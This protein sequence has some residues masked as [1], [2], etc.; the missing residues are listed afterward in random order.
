MT[1][2]ILGQSSDF[3][4]SARLPGIDGAFLGRKADF[5]RAP[6]GAKQAAQK[7]LIP[8]EIGGKYPSVAKA[9]VDSVGFMRG[10]KPPP[11]S[12]SSFS[13]ACKARPLLSAFCGT[14]EVVP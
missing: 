10:L 5:E 8:G 11:P 14:T 3:L 12:G 9:S 4:D 6:S 13:A 2:G 7:L 1:R